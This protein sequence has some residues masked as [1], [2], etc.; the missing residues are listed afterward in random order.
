MRMRGSE[1]FSRYRCFICIC[2]NGFLDD[3]EEPILHASVS[4]VVGVEWGGVAELLAL[5]SAFLWVGLFGRHCSV[6]WFR[7]GWLRFLLND[8][9]LLADDLGDGLMECLHFPTATGY[10]HLC[11]VLSLE[12][13]PTELDVRYVVESRF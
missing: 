3:V 6:R 9:L 11:G 1:G 2:K 4:P 8:L 13:I 10:L 5:C 12:L 7:D